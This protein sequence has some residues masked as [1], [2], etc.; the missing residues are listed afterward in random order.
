MLLVTYTQTVDPC[1]HRHTDSQRVSNNVDLLKRASSSLP[2]VVFDKTDK[3][4]ALANSCLNV[5][6]ELSLR[7]NVVLSVTVNVN[8]A[9]VRQ[10]PIKYTRADPRTYAILDNNIYRPVI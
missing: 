5:N 2:C 8:S 6:P 3:P 10:A 4:L 7:T 1:T 9:A